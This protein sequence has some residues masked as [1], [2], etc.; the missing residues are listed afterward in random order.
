MVRVGLNP[1]GLAYSLGIAAIGTP[2]VNPSPISLDAYL[3]IADGIGGTGIEL[4]GQWLTRLDEPSLAKVTRFVKDRDWWVVVARG[5][6]Q[7]NLDRHVALAKHLGAKILRSH[8]TPVLCGDRAAPKCNWPETWANARRILTET[9]KQLAP[10]GLKI[11]IENHQD[12]TAPELMELC[13]TCGDNVGITM[14][15]ANPVALGED[16]VEF[17]RTVEPRILHVHLKDYRAHWCDDGYRL[18][19][20]AVGD[21]FVPLNEVLA[22]FAKHDGLTAGLELGALDARY[23]R[24]LSEAWWQHYP[25]RPAHQLAMGLRAARIRCLKP[26]ED[27]RTPWERKEGPEAIMRFEQDQVRRSAQ[28]LAELG[29][30]KPKW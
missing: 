27:W 19:R 17:A 30:L 26:E 16:P 6:I 14:D 18:M 28:N 13:D 22:V 20:V 24:I 21:G 9:A 5:L 25:P 29:L 3:A 15:V 4:D 7:P 8:L 1:Y 11:A 12:V 23:V 10:H 2:K